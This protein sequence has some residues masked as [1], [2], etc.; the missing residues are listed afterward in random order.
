MLFINFLAI[1]AGGVIF[2][3]HMVVFIIMRLIQG[4]CVG[5]YTSIV[6]L[7]INEISPVEIES[8]TTPFTQIFCSCGATVA[9]LFYFIL[10]ISISDSQNYQDLIWYLVL[11]FPLIPLIV[12]TI[13]LLFVFPY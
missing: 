12:Q 13:V 4:I 9:Y 6:P 1:V 8:S 10:N 2:I 7:Y 5:M 11:G 3:N